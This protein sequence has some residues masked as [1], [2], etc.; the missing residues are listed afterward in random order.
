[1]LQEAMDECFGG[2]CTQFGLARVRRPVAKG[3]RRNKFRVVF[4]FDQAAVADRYSKNIGSQV[5]QGRAAI[6]HRFA[7]NSPILLP[8]L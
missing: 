7:V 8:D 5:F 1:M 2:E 3:H 6:A 4:E